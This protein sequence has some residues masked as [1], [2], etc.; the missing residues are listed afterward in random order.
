MWKT[1]PGMDAYHTQLISIF[2]AG[3]IAW[4]YL[5]RRLWSF[6][7]IPKNTKTTWTLAIIFVFSQ[8]MTLYYIWT[9]DDQLARENKELESTEN[10][11]LT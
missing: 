5:L 2:I 4:I 1:F 9:K 8:I 11:L 3:I 7:R 6:K 10:S